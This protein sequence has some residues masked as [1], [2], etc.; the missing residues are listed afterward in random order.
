MSAD[1]SLAVVSGRSRYPAQPVNCLLSDLRDEVDRGSLTRERLEERIA[2]FRAEITARPRHWD[3]RD[4]FWS[5]VNKTETCWLWTGTV[6]RSGYGY[7][8]L[9][10]RERRAH[11]VAYE[12]LVGE[13]P[14]GHGLHHHCEVKLCVNPAHLEPVTP[15]DHIRLTQPYRFNKP[16]PRSLAQ[17]SQTQDDS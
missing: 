12:L 11:R 14:E 1:N 2:Q 3:W 6:Q 4:R 8:T 5:K 10:R 9:D 17:P 15:R 13:I 7:F 16:G